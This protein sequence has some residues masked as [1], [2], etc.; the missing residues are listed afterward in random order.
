MDRTEVEAV[1]LECQNCGEWCSHTVPVQ[2]SPQGEDHEPQE[3]DEQAVTDILVAI[4]DTL[5]GHG[6]ERM[7][8]AEAGD[9][10]RDAVRREL[11]AFLERAPER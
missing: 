1:K 10:V 7:D 11:V 2:R 5:E 3:F 4:D 9:A 8:L 6:C